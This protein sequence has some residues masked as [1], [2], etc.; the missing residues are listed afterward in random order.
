MCLASISIATL[1]SNKLEP[2]P[3]VQ[4]IPVLSNT[5]FWKHLAKEYTVVL[6]DDSY[7]LHP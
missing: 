6:K 4:Y 5:F 7:L 1:L 2:I 3:I